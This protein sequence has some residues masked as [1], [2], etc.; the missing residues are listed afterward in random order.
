MVLCARNQVS[1]GEAM[2]EEKM[3]L[4]NTVSFVWKAILKLFV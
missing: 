4:V 3:I 2:E 1:L